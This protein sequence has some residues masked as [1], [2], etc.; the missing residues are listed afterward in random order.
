MP[1]SSFDSIK[2]LPEDPILSLPIHFRAD[3]R[4]KKVNLGIGAYE[5]ELG[6]S[7]V[8]NCVQEAEK[9]IFEKRLKKDYLPIEGDAGYVAELQRLIFGA[10]LLDKLGKRLF[11][12]QTI[13]GTGALR[14][15][16]EFVYH[17]LSKQLFVSNPT[18][19]NHHLIFHYAGL[20]VA[21]YPYY[22]RSSR[23]IVFDQLLQFVEKLPANSVLLLQPSCHNPTGVVPSQNQWEHLSSL[24]L[25]KEVIPFFDLAYQGLGKG[26]ESDAYI[27]NYFANQGHEMLVASSCSK[28]FGLYGERLG[29]LS[30]ISRNEAIAEKVASQIKKMIRACYSTPPLHGARIVSTVLKSTELREQWQQEVEMMRH[31]IQSMRMLLAKKLEEIGVLTDANEM[32][33]QEGLFSFIGLTEGQVLRL[34]EEFA[35]YLPKN[36]RINVAGLN[37]NNI[38]YVVNALRN[39]SNPIYK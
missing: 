39:L 21:E 13:G 12:A 29:M 22:D 10:P 3:P 17:N 34:R 35:I 28:N 24:M 18:W 2:L 14:I 5:D 9:I 6:L 38:D 15:G 11:G 37:V 25:K 23:S 7:K 16:G 4:A 19:P 33:N 30:V 20:E 27:V 36:G 1:N 26:L 8:L 32:S 31:R